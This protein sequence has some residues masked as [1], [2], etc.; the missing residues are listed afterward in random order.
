MKRLVIAVIV[1][2]LALPA[3][4]GQNPNLA[5]FLNT[6]P[7][8]SGTNEVCPAPGELFHVYVCFDRF[9]PG[10]GLLRVGFRFD[11]AFA[12]FLLEQQSWFPG[13]PLGD[14]EGDG[15]EVTA[16][17]ECVS[18]GGNGIVVAARITYLYTGGPGTITVLPHAYGEIADIALD[19]NYDIDHWCVASVA[20][21]GFSG[22]F[23]VC[24]PPP[25]RL[26]PL[27][28][29]CELVVPVEAET[30]GTIKGIYR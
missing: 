19:C 9:G 8:G 3:F 26:T 21:H 17:A 7:D 28:G 29:D 14:V 22:H 1:V 18:P 16:G 2:A 6:E 4:A 11:R 13:I 15:M 24:A 30:W 25:G 10:G 27:D 20:S 23:G 12:G 5:I